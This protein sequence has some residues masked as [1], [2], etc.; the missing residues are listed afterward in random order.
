MDWEKAFDKVDQEKLIEAMTRLGLPQKMIDVFA[1]FYV[2]PQFRVKDREGKS[3]YRRQRVGI[4][5]GC[6]LSPYVFIC[7]P[8][9]AGPPP[10]LL[11]WSGPHPPLWMWVV[12][13]LVVLSWCW[14]HCYVPAPPLWVWVV[15]G[16]ARRVEEK[17]REGERE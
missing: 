4:R 11:V 3:T 14:L 8:G 17:E 13:R 6:P 9:P 7:G 15:G 12:V 16:V 2:N 1:S 5:Q 10:V